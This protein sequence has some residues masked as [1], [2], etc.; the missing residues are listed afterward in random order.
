RRL[1]RLLLRGLRPCGGVRRDGEVLRPRPA[2]REDAG[3]GA[4]GGEGS[5]RRAA[6]H[7]QR[8]L[9]LAH[10]GASGTAAALRHPDRRWT[11]VAP[12]AAPGRCA[13][14][15]ESEPLPAPAAVA[16]SRCCC[17][18]ALLLPARAAVVCSCCCCLL[19]LRVFPPRE[20][21]STAR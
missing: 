21:V 18:L 2:A 15:R 7:G 19:A 1:H 3:A 5:R 8:L 6:A 4:A 13:L 20:Q 12:S 16:C 14:V 10:S 9:A 11:P 17:L